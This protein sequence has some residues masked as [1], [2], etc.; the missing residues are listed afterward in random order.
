MHRV[1]KAAAGKE[2]ERRDLVLS[3]AVSHV[4]R[5]LVSWY[6]HMRDEKAKRRPHRVIGIEW[7]RPFSSPWARERDGTPRIALKCHVP[8]QGTVASHSIQHMTMPTEVNKPTAR[9][10]GQRRM[11]REI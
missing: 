8:P 2:K 4:S 1:W 9:Q 10:S 3:L 5:E 11:P 7:N 6:T